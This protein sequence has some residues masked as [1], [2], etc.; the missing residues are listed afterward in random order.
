[1]PINSLSIPVQVRDADK[2][3]ETFALIDSGAGGKFIDQNYVRRLGIK[4][5][6][7]EQPLMWTEHQT[8]R[9]KLHPL[10]PLS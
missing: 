8:K 9:E 5:Q 10:S 6:E 4:T 1:M 7:L 3:V 2:T